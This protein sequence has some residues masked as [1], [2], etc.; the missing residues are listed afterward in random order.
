MK[1][2]NR[3]IY[4]VAGLLFLM[5]LSGADNVPWDTLAGK[6]LEVAN[7][8]E[9][10]GLEQKEDSFFEENSRTINRLKMLA[11]RL[12]TAGNLLSGEQKKIIRSTVVLLNGLRDQSRIKSEGLMADLAVALVSID[13][14]SHAIPTDYF[15]R[16]FPGAKIEFSERIDGKSLGSRVHVWPVGCPN[17]E[18]KG[19]VYYIKLIPYMG[20]HSRVM[21][22]FVYKVLENLGIGP[23][24]HFLGKDREYLYIAS[25]DVGCTDD[26]TVR[27]KSYNYRTIEANAEL[28][29]VDAS[30]FDGMVQED[31]VN[32][33]V[34][35]GL[36][37]GDLICRVF[38][39]TD[40]TTCRENFYF[41]CDKLGHITHFKIIDF[42]NPPI[43][44]TYLTT[45]IR[46]LFNGF[47]KG[48]G[49]YCLFLS[50]SADPGKIIR[51]FLA[52]RNVKSRVQTARKVFLPKVKHVPG[53]LDRVL[54]E[55]DAIYHSLTEQRS[56]PPLYSMY[57][58]NIKANVKEFAS[59]LRHYHLP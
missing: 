23:E 13:E 5:P 32:T 16:L 56:L 33:V 24:I 40:V 3:T 42:D 28:L 51:Y 29:G 49:P 15:L 17:V 19:F 9:N 35:E 46:G 45:P 44:I 22:L 37:L 31:K 36:V 14:V 57:A 50:H 12:K 43:Y 25:K 48:N 59:A 34:V 39:I 8:L 11:D 26:P 54:N 47:L 21:E 55:A 4:I 18:E 20:W 2:T 10:P 38:G 53:V 52:E 41:V 7:Q 27:F 30:T 1:R 58:E 6:V